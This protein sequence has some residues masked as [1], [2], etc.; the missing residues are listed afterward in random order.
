MKNKEIKAWG[1]KNIAT[2]KLSR[3]TFD[4][5]SE[6]LFNRLWGEE[7]GTYEEKVVPV[8]ITEVKK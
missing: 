2:G 5:K 4:L 1:L 3:V 6:A 8:K 7:E